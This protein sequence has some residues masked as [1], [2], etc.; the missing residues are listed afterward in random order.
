VTSSASKRNDPPQRQKTNTGTHLILAIGEEF[1]KKNL[2]G[3]ATAWYCVVTEFEDWDDQ[4]LMRRI[5]PALP[6]AMSFSMSE[7]TRTGFAWSADCQLIVRSSCRSSFLSFYLIMLCPRVGAPFASVIGFSSE[8]NQLGY[9]SSIVT[10]SSSSTRIGVRSSDRVPR[11]PR[12]SA[13]FQWK[14]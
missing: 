6:S 8:L 14:P 5:G 7:F 11:F 1:F 13:G 4:F 2:W 10:P 12:N 9:N 3:L